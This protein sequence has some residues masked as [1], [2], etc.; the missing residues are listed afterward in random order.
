MEFLHDKTLVMLVGPSCIGKSSLMSE[1]VR[2]DTAYGRV[3]GFVTRAPRPDDD[4]GMYRY[5]SKDEAARKIRDGETVQSAVSPTT[6]QIYGSEPQDYAATFNLLDTLANVVDELRLLPFERT[7]T[8]SLTAPAD[9]WRQW[10]LARYPKPSEDAQKRLEEAKLSIEWSLGDS[11]T[12]WLENPAGEL[13]KTAQALR[14]IVT[15]QPPRHTPENARALLTLL[16]KGLW[17]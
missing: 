8:I 6:G 4:P 12:Y 5:I 2:Q 7:V 13:A 17:N 1:A 15:S 3:S 11:Q 10:F 16:E 14:H 9:D